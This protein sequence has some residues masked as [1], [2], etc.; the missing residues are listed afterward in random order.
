MTGRCLSRPARF[1]RRGRLGEQQE[2]VGAPGRLLGMPV[3][4]F[5]HGPVFKAARQYLDG[6]D[7]RLHL[8]L[9]PVHALL[10]RRLAG[11]AGWW[12][13]CCVHDTDAAPLR[14]GR[15]GPLVLTVMP[16]RRRK[17]R[18]HA[19]TVM[20]ADQ[21]PAAPGR[22]RS[23]GLQNAPGITGRTGLPHHGRSRHDDPVAATRGGVSGTVEACLGVA[24]RGAAPLDERAAAAVAHLGLLHA[25][26]AGPQ[27][28]VW[29]RQQAW[30]CATWK[31]R[32]SG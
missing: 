17:G 27:L 11:G 15:L 28:P 16:G 13:R 5:G 21:R 7:E 8:F 23:S 12:L 19:S 3:R 22:C 31:A 1:A 32:W 18:P 2:F 24:R 4:R 26:A 9:Q 10:K 14:D 30:I 6:L 20:L 25:G 29:Q